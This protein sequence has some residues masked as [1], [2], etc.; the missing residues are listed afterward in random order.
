MVFMVR[1]TVGSAR[2]PTGQEL[3]EGAMRIRGFVGDCVAVAWLAIAGW[4]SVWAG[5][6]AVSDAR[7]MRRYG[8]ARFMG[9]SR[10]GI[11]IRASLKIPPHMEG[12]RAIFV[13]SWVGRGGWSAGADEAVEMDFAE[14]VEAEAV[15]DRD[16]GVVGGDDVEAGDC[17]VGAMIVV[18]CWWGLTAPTRRAR[19]SFGGRL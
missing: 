6:A 15:I 7:A 10:A 17:V 11:R 18:E 8:V 3:G 9:S 19:A 2:S 1:P 13:F 14:G 5:R 4:E 12:G 16:G